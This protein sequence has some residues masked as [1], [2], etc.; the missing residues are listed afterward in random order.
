M[1]QHDK[2]EIL[3]EMI[4]VVFVQFEKEPIL[5]GNLSTA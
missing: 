3:I 5:Q 4:K 1:N 2:D